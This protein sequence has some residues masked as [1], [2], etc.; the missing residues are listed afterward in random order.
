MCDGW[1]D[2]LTILEKKTS[3]VIR[4]SYFDHCPFLYCYESFLLPSRFSKICCLL[5]CQ[6]GADYSSSRVS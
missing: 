3:K 4:S 2:C 1:L 6:L 5:T